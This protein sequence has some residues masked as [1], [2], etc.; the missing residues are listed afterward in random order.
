MN[1]TLVCGICR[2]QPCHLVAGGY[3][4]CQPGGIGGMDGGEQEKWCHYSQLAGR[5]R[6]DCSTGPCG[7]QAPG[8]QVEPAGL[9]GTG[10][11]PPSQEPY[12]SVIIITAR[13]T[14]AAWPIAIRRQT[15]FDPTALAP[16]TSKTWRF[17]PV[18][19][20][21]EGDLRTQ[22]KRHRV[23]DPWSHHPAF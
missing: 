9:G 22:M 2:S 18:K 4:R 23:I 6:M 15:C 8:V 21:S 11:E 12:C 5:H 1:F 7:M 3:A 16:A 17:D 19:L 14:T 10:E 13:G 20:A